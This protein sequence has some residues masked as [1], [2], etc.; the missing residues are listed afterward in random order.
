MDHK[1]EESGEGV[2]IL[3]VNEG[4]EDCLVQ[5]MRS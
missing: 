3:D 5:K 1:T 2:K 4:G